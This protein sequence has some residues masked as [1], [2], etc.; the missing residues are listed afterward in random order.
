[1]FFIDPIINTVPSLLALGNA[2]GQ[3]ERTQEF[4][5]F[6]RQHM[7][8]VASRLADVPADQRPKV[9]LHAHAGSTECCNSPGTGT[10]NDMITYAGGH[11]IGADVLKSGTGRLNFEYINSRN[12]AVYIATGTGSGKRTHSGLHIGMGTSPRSE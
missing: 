11:N 9:F 6:Y 12:P 10:F 1:D 5:S 7:D 3:P 2:I 8:K 4:I